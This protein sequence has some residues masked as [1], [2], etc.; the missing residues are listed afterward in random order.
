MD[1]AEVRFPVLSEEDP[2]GRGEL[3]TWFVDDG[4]AVRAGQLLAEVQ[5]AKVTDEVVA[6]RDGVVELLVPAGT[7][8]AQ[9]E[10]L[11]RIA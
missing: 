3:A 1:V 10:L 7:G 9:G 8:V 5:V 2:H 6:P 11:A 4:D